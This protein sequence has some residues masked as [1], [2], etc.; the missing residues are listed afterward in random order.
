MLT[1]IS[2]DM[3]QRENCSKRTREIIEF[4]DFT[5][6][7]NLIN[8]QLKDGLHTW[9]RRGNQLIASRVDRILISEE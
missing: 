9:F 5:E 1:S 3:H 4:S 8:L 2:L 7:M 6:D